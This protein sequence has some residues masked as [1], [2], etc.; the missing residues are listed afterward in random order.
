MKIVFIGGR[1]I[2]K[3]GGIENYMYNL[4]SCLVSL[5]HVPI[6]FCESNKNRE[7]YVNGFK[8]IYVK[9]PKSALICKPY[10]SLVATLWTVFKIKNVDVIHYNAWPPSIWSFIPR[11]FGITSIMQGH[12]FEWK[13]SKYSKFQ[14]KIMKFMEMLTAHTNRNLI[15]CSDEQTKYFLA[16]YHRTAVT[17][18]TAINLPECQTNNSSEILKRFGIEAGKYILFM[19]RLVQDKNPDYLINAFDEIQL[20]NFKLVIAGDNPSDVNYVANLKN[21]ARGNPNVIFTGAVFGDDKDS[22]L[23]NAFAFCIP[24]TIEGLSIALL[25]AISYKLPI[26][27]SDIFANREVLTSDSALWVVP[28]DVESLKN[29]II[30]AIENSSMFQNMVDRNFDYIKSNYTWEKVTRKYISYLMQL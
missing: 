16:H 24:S 23:R 1:D 30:S 28:E 22:L 6:V 3:I 13:R 21:L 7:E 18:P 14:Q 10:V 27:A 19:A 9:G 5:G 17:I 8:V 25:E 29:A 15:M 20:N 4:S 2:H 12:G 11:I 26:I